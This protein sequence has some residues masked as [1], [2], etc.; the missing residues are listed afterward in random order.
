MKKLSKYIKLLY[1]VIVI[2]LV[3]KFVGVVMLVVLPKVSIEKQIPSDFSMN[4]KSYQS[5]K[6]FA[7]KQT[8]DEVLKIKKPTYDLKDLVLKAIYKDVNG[9]IIV[10]QDLKTKEAIVLEKNETY[11]GYKLIEIYAKYV[12]FLKN[13]KRYTLKLYDDVNMQDDTLSSETS[14]NKTEKENV[15]VFKKDILKYATNF[16]AIWRNISI[17]DVK[18][19]GKLVGFKVRYVRQRSAF[20]KLG[21]KRGDIITKVNYEPLTSYSQAFKIYNNIKEYNYLTITIIRDG[22]EKDLDYEI[23]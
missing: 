8:K 13:K 9:G 10:V 16:D 17:D 5:D 15:T 22:K 2:A 7:L 19:D 14:Q 11:K 1:P 6:Q 18:K 20:G 3:A 21:L 23:R 12:V 4:F